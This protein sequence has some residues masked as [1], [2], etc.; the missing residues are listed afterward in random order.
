MS[1]PTRGQVRLPLV[2]AG[3][4]SLVDAARD[5]LARFVDRG[6]GRAQLGARNG[7]AR[8]APCAASPRAHPRRRGLVFLNAVAFVARVNALQTVRHCARRARV[9]GG[10]GRRASLGKA[11]GAHRGVR[12]GIRNNRSAPCGAAEHVVALHERAFPIFAFHHEIAG[13]TDSRFRDRAGISAARCRLGRIATWAVVRGSIRR[14]VTRLRRCV[15]CDAP[16]IAVGRGRRD[17]AAAWKCRQGDGPRIPVQAGHLL[18]GRVCH[19]LAA[20]NTGVSVR[21]PSGLVHDRGAVGFRCGR[22]RSR[23]GRREPG[24]LTLRGPRGPGHRIRSSGSRTMEAEVQRR[25]CNRGR[26][27]PRR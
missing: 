27:M 4:A 26:A 21:P 22:S 18:S 10:A 1:F 9:D 25:R 5:L 19:G 2:S 20:V 15:S 3:R 6:A 11:R 7:T 16:R 24:R 23:L 8:Q 13:V 17:A 12:S 14:D